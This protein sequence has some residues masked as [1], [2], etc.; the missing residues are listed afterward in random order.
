MKKV[1][2]L[3]VVVMVLLLSV[4]LITGCNRIPNNSH[5]RDKFVS[6]FNEN[7]EA[8]AK[9]IF[10]FE[11]DR[12][13]VF[14]ECYLSGEGLMVTYDLDS[15]IEEVKSGV[16]ERL[17]RIIFVDKNGDL[18]YEFR[19]DIYEMC[20]EEMDIVIRPE[21]KVY[22]VSAAGEEPLKIKFDSTEYL[23]RKDTTGSTSSEQ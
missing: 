16:T 7:E 15:S 9:D 3:L 18:V 21:T 14:K 22:R 13:F 2:L 10:S 20:I 8:T 17:L 1:K 6:V 5:F 12:A 11:F 23:V 4:S 19:Y